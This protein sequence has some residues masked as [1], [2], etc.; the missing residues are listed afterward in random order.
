MRFRRLIMAFS[1]EERRKKRCQ[2]DEREKERLISLSDEE[3]LSCSMD[4][5][6]EY[7]QKKRVFSLIL[8]V[9]CIACIGNTWKAFMA[10]LPQLSASSVYT[11][12][13]METLA[14]TWLVLCIV[15]S[16]ILLLALMGYLRG[17]RRTHR[18]LLL[19]ESVKEMR[20]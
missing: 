3:L 20:R 1:G 7:E 11:A 14:I 9:V 4:I 13:D 17:M 18:M 5:K 19:V 16:G 2:V 10:L 12:E 6:T 15:I 8:V